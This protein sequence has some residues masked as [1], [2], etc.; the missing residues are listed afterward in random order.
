MV[1]FG[2]E[3]SRAR[4]LVRCEGR[5]SGED[6]MAVGD[7]QPQSGEQAGTRSSDGYLSLAV[8]SS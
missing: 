6:G 5:A 2:G 7:G 8:G 4:M 3:R 1:F